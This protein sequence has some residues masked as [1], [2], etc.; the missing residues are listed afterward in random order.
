MNLEQI[1][2]SKILIVEDDQG[3]GKLLTEEIQDHGMEV[4]WASSAEEALALMDKWVP[5]LV[6]SDL[7]LPDMD[8]LELL[9]RVKSEYSESQPDFLIITAFGNISKAV[10][11]LKA[12]AED[13]LAK[14]LDLDI[15]NLTVER[16]L[17]NR[18]LRIEVSQIKDLLKSDSFHGMYGQS[19]TMRFLFGQITR[20]AQANGP[21]LILGESG[22]GKE[23]AAKAIHSESNRRDNPFLAVNCA[24][25]P[26]HLL[27]SEFFGHKAGAFT[28]A[29]RSRRG[30]FAE[31]HGGTLLLDEIS[32]MPLFMQAKVLRLL[33]DYK[34]RP[35]GSNQEEQVDVR[36]LTATN[37]ELEEEV[38][39]GHFRED[40]FYRLETFTLR[41]PPMRERENDLELLAERMLRR[42][43]IQTG[44]KIRRFSEA[45]LQVLKRYHFPG[46]VRELQNAVE[47]A[48]TFCD[49]PEILSRHLPT[50]IREN[51]CPIQ[52]QNP[53]GQHLRGQD[54]QTLP[55]LA[56]VEK[57]YIQHVLDRVGGNKRRAASILGIG[58]RTLYRRLGQKA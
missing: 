36:I 46:N 56:E 2:D 57:H 8:G 12:G 11:A 7:R 23:L 26:E 28:G 20:V 33:Q 37:R 49:G 18:A 31:A 38:R 32:E 6:T 4:L 14:P 58:R 3:L 35:V 50:R 1:K 42:C 45:A 17:R 9:K 39:H 29:Y 22:T 40:L 10:E 34:V 27:E 55:P 30:I 15:F 19:R 52:E 41:V 24:G 13:F 44:K 48:V 21:V 43:C 16:I 47:R 53:D 51:Q 5:D 25:I 54:Q